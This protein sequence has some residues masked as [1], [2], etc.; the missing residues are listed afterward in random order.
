M[1]LAELVEAVANDERS[2]LG[3]VSSVRDR[4]ADR[5]IST[6]IAYNLSL[7]VA[8]MQAAGL[9]P[10]YEASMG[11]M[12]SSE[13]GQEIHRVAV[14]AFGLHSQLWPGDGREVLD[15]QHIR[16]YIRSI[17][18]TIAGGS[19]EVQRNIIA[20]RGLGLPRG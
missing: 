18:S 4:V 8:S 2:L 1:Q 20:T 9:V 16:G 12:F 6:E 10:N 15:G 11:K 7:R 5:Y 13:Q 17:P 19:S 14:R 3:R